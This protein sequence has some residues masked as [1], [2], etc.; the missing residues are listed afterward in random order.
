VGWLG[1]VAFLAAVAAFLW[2]Y[3]PT[4]ADLAATWNR[5]PDYSHGFLV[6]PV[7]VFFLWIR[8][9]T[10]PGVPAGL[11][12]GGLGLVAVSIA[13]RML[14]A[15]Y[16]VDA[17]DGWSILFWVAGVVW[18][19]GGRRVLRWS[20][21]S[22]VFL[23]FMVPLPF[24]VERMLSLP[25]QR[26]ATKLSCWVLQ[27]FGQPALAEGNS[28][29]L[30]DRTIGIEQACSGLR[31]FM[32][33]VALAFAYFVLVRR[34]WWEKALLLASVVPIALVANVTRIAGVA[35]VEQLATS[36]P[37]REFHERADQYAGYVMIPFAAALFAL[38]LWYVGRLMRTA[39]VM[40]VGEV[41]RRERT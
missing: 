16:Y 31:I 29:L 12:W 35:L 18:F 28:I 14:G 24:R 11:A 37:S 34:P 4:L 6:L 36:G 20:L 15:R 22:I 13:L 39:E 7:A 1:V 2:A 23:W 41:L 9:D 3:W 17:I 38:V 32:G 5:E 40:D 10:F 27:F 19:L 21:P 8:R 26:V 30:G 25:L 33:I